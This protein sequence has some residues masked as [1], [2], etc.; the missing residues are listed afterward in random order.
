MDESQKTSANAVPSHWV[1]RIIIAVL[2]AEGAWGLI[3]SLTR[4]LLVPLMARGLPT[5]PQSPL[6][7][8]KG[9][10]DFSAVFVAFLQFCFAAL[11]AAILNAWVQR[12][13]KVIR[14]KT[15][16]RT[17]PASATPA[18]LSIRSEP[19]PAAP[20]PPVVLPPSEP[21]IA[22]RQVAPTPPQ[23]VAPP[24]KPKKP[25]EVYYN[26]VGEPINPTENDN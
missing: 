23:P 13:V 19:K 12:G 2:I 21:A 16:M 18:P 7:L 14:V 3:V 11:V 15:V 8:G 4:G 9:D 5:D 10:F 17:V 6:Y 20:S 24:P 25:Q 1:P 26:I 22:P